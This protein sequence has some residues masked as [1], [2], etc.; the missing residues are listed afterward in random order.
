MDDT[1]IVSD[2]LVNETRFEYR[3][4]NS[5]SSP[6]STAPSFSV[7]GSFSGGGNGG[8][9]SNSHM[10]HYE[11]QNFTTLTKGTQAIKFGSWMRDDR[12][13]ITTNGN[14]NGSI[15]AASLSGSEQSSF[16]PFGYGE[17]IPNAVDPLPALPDGLPIAMGGLALLGFAGL[18]LQ[19][20]SRRRRAA[21]LPVA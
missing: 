16:D 18:V 13:A 3:R 5:S 20:R 9:F 21:G 19:R 4:T 17:P 10:D 6:V 15:F 7:P 1:Q 14:F 12:E 2:R 11:L 8:Q